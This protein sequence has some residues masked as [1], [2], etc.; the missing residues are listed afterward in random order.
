MK[1]CDDNN[2]ALLAALARWYRSPLGRYVAA[3]EQRC[4]AR[5]LGD[6]FGRYLVQIG[7]PDQFA[8][9]VAASRLRH[10][11][12]LGGVSDAA[13]AGGVRA[14]PHLPIEGVA[15]A[16]PLES[17]GVDVL[18]LPHSLD[19][20]S[21]PRQVLREVERVLIPNGRVI[22]FGFNPISAWGLTRWM[23]RPAPRVPW[24]GEQLTAFR[25][26]DWLN[27]LGIEVERREMLM[28][29]PPVRGALSPRL[30][31]LDRLGG[32][33]WPALGGVY[34]IVAIKR[35]LP[36]TP[37]RPAWSATPALVPGGAVE[38]TARE[39]GHV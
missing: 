13:W 18:F 11:V 19:I 27:V 6:E 38:P 36:L 3:A 26:G 12:V 29:R 37:L 17:A 33:Y 21:A 20:S 31:W 22:L 7:V 1:P 32:R 9:A 2:D 30:D 35:V 16:L 24:C 34:G 5:L 14:T 23:P 15:D 25:I 39:S 28:F 4:L 10:R 8:A